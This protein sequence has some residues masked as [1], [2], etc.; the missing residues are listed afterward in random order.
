MPRKLPAIPAL[1]NLN[2]RKTLSIPALLKNV[3]QSFE[4]IKDHR[5]KK[6]EYSLQDILMSGLAIFGLKYPSLLAFDNDRDKP[7]LKHNLQHLYGV[8]D[9]VPCDTRLREVL[10]KVDPEDLRPA[11]VDIIQNVQRQGELKRF[12]YLGGYLVS[13]DG[14]A[15]YSSTKISCPDCCEKHHRNGNIE[16]YHQLLAS[17]IVH[18]DI[19]TVLPLFHEAIKKGDGNTKNDC[20]SNASKRLLPA[21]KKGF[22]RLKMIIIEDSLSGNGPHIKVLREQGFSHITRVKYGS[23][24]SLM[25]HAVDCMTKGETDEFE[26]LGEDGILR[27]TRFMNQIPLNKTHKELLVNYLEYW[28]VDKKGK[29]KNFNWITDITLSRDNVYEVM[30]AGR[31]RWKIENET[32]NTLKN[33]G[34]NFE[35]NYGHGKKYLATV[36]AEL[37]M[38]AF[39]LDQV[40]ELSCNVFNAARHRYY[41]KIKFWTKLQSMF[42]EH[43]I[44]DWETLYMGIIFGVKGEDRLLPEYPDTS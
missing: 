36:F 16:Y 27:G 26:E 7:R 13:L 10:D 32:F 34:Y 22:P 30:R 15:H 35:H 41:S 1:K 14:T 20:E 5:K 29:T 3:R 9:K 40:Q 25:D 21:L 23:N 39:L 19:K 42:T 2:F 11:T 33:L 44:D 18:P 24:K 28:E 12:Q 6:T 43:Y 8:K 31:A 17:S 37:M 4:K 38:L